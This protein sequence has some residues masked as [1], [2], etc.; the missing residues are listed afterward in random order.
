MRASYIKILHMNRAEFTLFKAQFVEASRTILSE[1]RSNVLAEA[2]FP[3]YANRNPL[4]SFLFWRR[5]RV[6]MSFLQKQGPFET[7]LDFGCGGGVML[8]FLG[9]IARRVVAV[10]KELG[11]LKRMREHLEFPQNIETADASRNSIQSLGHKAF[12]VVT[13]LDVLE[14][15][16]IGRAHV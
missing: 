4:A 8:P 9:G 15:V 3:A 12:D 10:D 16:E 14:H 7:V 6:V 13:A 11:P 2:A 1:E 5:I